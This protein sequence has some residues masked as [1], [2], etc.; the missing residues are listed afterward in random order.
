MQ[1]SIYVNCFVHAIETAHEVL[2]NFGADSD[3]LS[4]K[5]ITSDIDSNKDE[6]NDLN[7]VTNTDDE[8]TKRMSYGSILGKG[9]TFGKRFGSIL[10][11]GYSLGKKFGYVLGRGYGFGKRDS[12]AYQQ[13]ISGL[14]IWSLMNPEDNSYTGIKRESDLD[15]IGKDFELVDL[16]SP[17][18]EKR[19]DVDN[20]DD[21][22]RSK[23]DIHSMRSRR[24]FGNILGRGFA[25]GKKSNEYNDDRMND[26]LLVDPSE[27]SESPDVEK[28][29]FSRVLGKGYM[30]GKR[31]YNTK[32]RRLFG[33]LLGRGYA[34]GKRSGDSEQYESD[35]EQSADDKNSM[36]KRYFMTSPGYRFK[37]GKRF[38]Y[39]LGNGYFGKRGYKKSYHNPSPFGLMLG[40]G[41][42]FGKRSSEVVTEIP[43]TDSHID[44]EQ[45]LQ[46]L[47]STGSD[48][49]SSYYRSRYDIFGK[50][51]SKRFGY[52]LGRGFSMGKRDGIENMDD[53]KNA[54]DIFVDDNGN[55]YVFRED[56]D[57]I[58]F[59]QSAFQEDQPSVITCEGEIVPYFLESYGD[60]E[61]RSNLFFDKLADKLI[62]NDV[63]FTDGL[64]NYFVRVND[65]GD[66]KLP[67][68]DKED[69]VRYYG[70]QGNLI[71]LLDS[72]T[73][74]FDFPTKRNYYSQK[75]FGHILGHGFAFG[76]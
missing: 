4:D 13:G 36:S 64:G 76:K 55:M 16:E 71:E 32:R 44:T 75:R 52:I 41:L 5:T 8:V 43:G 70:C 47:D 12:V 15:D 31:L 49:R 30:F 62:P 61:K 6:S 74:N 59:Q 65:P 38:G 29:L 9:L 10:G 63:Y 35:V 53:D 22:G 25:F 42:A 39:I 11:R 56:V 68:L 2:T 48:K 37:F 69:D 3:K 58:L 1:L 45:I 72:D 51:G 21:F 60:F 27:L 26:A 54:A 34:F 40:R 50:R 24:Y 67:I 66:D 14:S 33:N 17:I 23:R 57:D 19:F 46:E 7:D 18:D 73:E 28:R 20:D